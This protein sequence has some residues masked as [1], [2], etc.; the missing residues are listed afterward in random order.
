MEKSLKGMLKKLIIP[1]TAVGVFGA[2]HLHFY[3]ANTWE[4]VNGDKKWHSYQKAEIE[5]LFTKKIFT[6]WDDGQGKIHEAFF[7]H[8]TFK[9]GKLY[10][11][12]VW[13]NYD[14]KD[15]LIDEITTYPSSFSGRKSVEITREKDY[16]THSEEFDVA[17][18]EFARIRKPYIA[19]M[20][21]LLAN[22]SS[23]ES[24]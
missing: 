14:N 22:H 18:E 20:E 16:D 13:P 15:G 10:G 11:D 4:H 19:R 2:C 21:K 5:G 23:L 8:H 7:K 9:G 24:M 3:W 6:S 12:S 1:I 17:S